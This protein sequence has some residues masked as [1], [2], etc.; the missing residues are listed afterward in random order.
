MLGIFTKESRAST[1]P[2]SIGLSQGFELLQHPA[3]C[4]ANR[5]FMRMQLFFRL[6]SSVREF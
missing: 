4:I 6:F 1:F 3:N 5:G 2:S